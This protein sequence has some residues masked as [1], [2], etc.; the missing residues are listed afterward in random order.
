MKHRCSLKVVSWSEK[1][2]V[3]W[4]RQGRP[5]INVTANKK[6]TQIWAN[7]STYNGQQ[8][9]VGRGDV[10]TAECGYYVQ[11]EDILF[12]VQLSKEPNPFGSMMPKKKSLFFKR[13]ARK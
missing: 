2:N 9:H 3:E 11:L 13:G 4:V 10:E 12:T 1:P 6:I 5:I 7:P 8:A